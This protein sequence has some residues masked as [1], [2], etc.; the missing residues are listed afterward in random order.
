MTTNTP[1]AATQVT[2]PGAATARTILQAVAGSI[3][4]GATI[5]AAL[6]VFAPQFL[7]AIAD[8]LP[9]EWLAWATGAVAAIG[10]FAGALARVMA[11]PG[12]NAWLTTVKLGAAGKHES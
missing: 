11:I 2:H 4:T 8:I 6:A 10:A 12:V 9:A 3:L 1:A 7:A 5:V